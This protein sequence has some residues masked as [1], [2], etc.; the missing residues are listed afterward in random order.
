MTVLIKREYDYAIRI[1]V[2]L[3]DAYGGKPIALSK[4]A[5][6]LSLT[7]PFASKIVHQLRKKEII[8]SIQ[9]KLGG[10]FLKV[11]PAK[12][13]VMDVLEAMDFNS[14]LNEC[15]GNHNICPF[16]GV[17][18]IHAFFKE[19]EEQLFGRFR[20]KPIADFSFKNKKNINLIDGINQRHE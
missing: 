13:S 11:D 6:Q 17:C 9:G 8:G 19:Q 20:E 15:I 2:F 7:R 16:I 3:S 14:T 12:L 5:K 4:I 1:C 18:D 10:I